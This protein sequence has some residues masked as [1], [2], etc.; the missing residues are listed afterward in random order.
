MK[1]LLLT[2]SRPLLGD[3]GG[4]SIGSGRLNIAC[5]ERSKLRSRSRH[6]EGAAEP[7]TP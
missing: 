1:H 3:N 5:V 6:E 4:D 7:S 2:E